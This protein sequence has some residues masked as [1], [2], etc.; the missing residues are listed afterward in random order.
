MTRARFIRLELQPRG[1]IE[2][3][4]KSLSSTTVITV[5]LYCHSRMIG[6]ILVDCDNKQNRL[7]FR[8]VCSFEDMC[9]SVYYMDR[10]SIC[11][12]F[13]KMFFF[14]FQWCRYHTFYEQSFLPCLKTN[15]FFTKTTHN[16]PPPSLI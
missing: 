2:D 12:R 4:V 1:L 11:E 9:V 5:C 10:N 16:T 6:K 3:K 15:A 14:N 8:Y 7:H 13:N